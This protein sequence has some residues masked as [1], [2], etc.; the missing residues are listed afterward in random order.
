MIKE[1]KCGCGTMTGEQCW[2]SPSIEDMVVIEWM[3]EDLR[4]S[5]EAAG[6]C[7]RYPAN[8]AVRA[9]V[10]RSCAEL[11]LE[12]DGDWAEIVQ[13]DPVQYAEEA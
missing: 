9:A 11:I 5:H 12:E 8:G 7:G 1:Y 6:N 13:A 2:G 3:P 4:Q 10:A